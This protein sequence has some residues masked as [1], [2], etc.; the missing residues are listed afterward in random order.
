MGEQWR[1]AARASKWAAQLATNTE[2]G[3]AAVL[4][5][6]TGVVGMELSQR[7]DRGCSRTHAMANEGQLHKGMRREVAPDEP[8]CLSPLAV[9]RR[10][11]ASP[12][13]CW[14]SGPSRAPPAGVPLPLQMRAPGRRRLGCCQDAEKQTMGTCAARVA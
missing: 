1:E 2:V 8:G 5:L 11:G 13:H 7:T 6:I 10:S 12:A 14:C 3:E 9:R 4:G